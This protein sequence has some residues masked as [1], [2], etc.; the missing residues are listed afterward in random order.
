MQIRV[1]NGF[2]VHRFVKAKKLRLCGIDIDF[3]KGLS[4]HS[5][6]DVGLH[7]L[8]DAILGALGKGDIGIWFPPSDDQWKDVDSKIFLKF[9]YDSLNEACLKISN[10]DITIICE[11]PKVNEYTIMMKNR[12]AKML[13]IKT[14]LLMFINK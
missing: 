12:L 11:Q 10:I 14:G 5:D 6:A 13:L 4:G 8:T 7:A 1:G 2:D 3:D 9:A